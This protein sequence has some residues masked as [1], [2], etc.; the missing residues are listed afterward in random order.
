MKSGKTPPSSSSGKG[1]ELL[2]QIV[3]PEIVHVLS[4]PLRTPLPV[5]LPLATGIPTGH[6][7][8]SQSGVRAEPTPANT[9]GTSSHRFLSVL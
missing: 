4:V 1:L 6:L 9:A 2:L 5:P 8:I 7:T 3:S